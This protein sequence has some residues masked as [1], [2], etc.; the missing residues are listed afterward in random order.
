MTEETRGALADLALLGAAA[1]ATYLVVKTPP[2]RRAI[3]PMLKYGLFTAVP[4]YLWQ[5]VRRAW[6]ES[7]PRLRARHPQPG[8]P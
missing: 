8:L 5:E 1:V 4:T 6:E 3:W 2:L 7:D